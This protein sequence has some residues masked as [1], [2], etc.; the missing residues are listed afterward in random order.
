ML[1]QLGVLGGILWCLPYGWANVSPPVSTEAI[2]Q[3]VLSADKQARSHFLQ[4][5]QLLNQAI[6]SGK[7]SE[8]VIQLAEALK[9]KDY[10]LQ[11][12]ADGLILTAK[13]QAL[14]LS[15]REARMQLR[16]QFI[17]RYPQSVQRVALAQRPFVEDSQTG[18]FA[19][20]LRYAEK[21]APVGVEN[22]CYFWHAQQQLG[23]WQAEG[24]VAFAALWQRTSAL[25]EA[26][27]PLWLAWQA[28]GGVGIE[29]VKGKVT[30]LLT[31]WR[32]ADRQTL[33]DAVKDETL[34]AWLNAAGE[35]FDAPSRLPNFAENQPLDVWNARIVEQLFPAFIRTQPE[36]M[37][38]AMFQRYMAWADKFQLS[39]ETKKSWTVA[40]LQRAFDSHEAGFAV[41]R[42]EQLRQLNHD[43]LTERRIRLALRQG[44][45]FAP[46][47]ARLSAEARE[48][49]E[50]RYWR[51][52]ADPQQ[53][54]VLW[55][56]L[57]RERGFYAMLSAHQLGIDYQPPLQ[58]SA[59]LTA[60]QYAHYQ[61]L[62]SRVAE[63]RELNRMES[64]KRL[65][66][67]Q[68]QALDDGQKI[69]LGQAAFAEGWYDLAV[70]ATIQA[71]AWDY[72]ALRLPNA[73]ADWFTLHLQGSPISRSFAM[74]IARQ[75]SAWNASARSHANAIGLMQLL[76]STAKQTAE[77][78]GLPYQGEADLLQPFSNIMLGTAHL[79]QLHARY[80]NNRILIAAAYNAGS[81]R[82]DNWLTRSGGKLAWDHFIA[83]IPFAETRGYVQNVLAYDYY[84]RWLQPDA[85]RTLFYPEE[86][87]AY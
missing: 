7:V 70:E 15:E 68:L 22:Q 39:D 3:R 34:H 80:P 74:A 42:D 46:W 48:K 11:E 54:D 82:V 37:G 60:A 62:L 63:L 1:K 76:P 45:D 86:L 41:W 53:R 85:P 38:Q 29:T 55:Q 66:V 40:F 79:A 6:A 81:H 49:E 2:P 75:E 64:A 67:A 17:A 52:K 13:L 16:Q 12:E 33:K 27:Q 51:G 28:G 23:Q 36:Q 32:P 31:Q 56:A 9:P 73:Y 87:R 44:E 83:A 78:V 47:L 8:R 19:E 26:C 30:T 77:Q 21:V 71:K 72:L 25:P 58:Q 24:M 10:P 18:K 4:L 69:V 59:P 84:Y 65:W 14:P 61:P 5:E 50:W 57:S 43:A 20:L 35:V